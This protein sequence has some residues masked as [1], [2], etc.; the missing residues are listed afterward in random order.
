[1]KLMGYEIRIFLTALLAALG[2]ALPAMGCAGGCG[3]C[4][5]CAG[6]GGVAAIA[7]VLGTARRRNP[8]EGGKIAN[9]VLPG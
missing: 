8:G 1:M 9:K 4:L 3:A 5:G 6:L 2:T 7:S